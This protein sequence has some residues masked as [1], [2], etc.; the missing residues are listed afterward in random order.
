MM[1]MT[2]KMYQDKFFD[3]QLLRQ[4]ELRQ[5]YTTICPWH[6]ILNLFLVAGQLYVLTNDRML[7]HALK[8]EDRMLGQGCPMAASLLERW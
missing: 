6:L 3:F 2:T 7:C 1:N 5:T 4:M 8:E